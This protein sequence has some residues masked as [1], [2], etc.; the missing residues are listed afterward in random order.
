MP[1]RYGEGYARQT[2]NGARLVDAAHL[3]GEAAADRGEQG[4]AGHGAPESPLPARPT[5]AGPLEV[6]QGRV[7][8][9]SSP[10]VSQTISPP[11]SVRTTSAAL[12]RER[13]ERERVGVPE[14][15]AHA[16]RDRRQRRS[17]GGEERRRAR[18]AAPVVPDLEQ[19]GPQRAGCAREQRSLLFVLGVAHQQ[20]RAPPVGEP[21][22]QR[23]VVGAR[24]GQRSP[25]QG[26]STSIVTPPA[27]RGAPQS[28]WG[29]RMGIPRALAPARSAA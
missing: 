1:A 20:R 22:H 21:Q 26:A 17:D 9:T 3:G 10:S 24:V 29:R 2:R 5:Q 12:R 23:A 27:T 15:V 13:R 14:A 19:I 4:F 18:R 11:R 28:S 8:R 7:T 6:A 16:R 25:G